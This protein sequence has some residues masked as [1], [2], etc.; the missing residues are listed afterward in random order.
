MVGAAIFGL[1]ERST[2]G[3]PNMTGKM[4]SEKIGKLHFI[5]SFYGFNLLSSRCFRS[6]VDMPRRYL[7]LLRYQLAPL[8]LIAT[9]GAF[10]FALAQFLFI[11]N[12]GLDNPVR[13]LP[14]SP[15]RGAA[16][17]SSGSTRYCRWLNSP[18]G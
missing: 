4:F 2:T 17:R 3:F 18:D 11:G 6:L 5:F 1:M 14:P 10:V 12:I 8:N 15:T 9:G 7:H 16:P 13:S